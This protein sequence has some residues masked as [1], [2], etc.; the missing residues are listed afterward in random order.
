MAGLL[1][2][3]SSTYY[4]RRQHTPDKQEMAGNPVRMRA[5][6]TQTVTVL[7]VINDLGIGGAQRIVAELAKRIDHARFRPIVLNLG[8]SSGDEIEKEL[9]KAGVVVVR[10][11]NILIFDITNIY[12]I[13]STIRNFNVSIVHSHLFRANLIS[14]LA[15]RVA[16]IKRVVSTE[17][18]TTTFTTR[19]WWYKQASRVYLHRN[20]F[21]LAVSRAVAAAIASL[22]QDV[23]H[24]TR[25]IYNGID[26]TTFAPERYTHSDVK[27]SRPDRFTVGALLRPD[28]RKGFA[29]LQ[30][31]SQEMQQSDPGI[32]FVMGY[33]EKRLFG[34]KADSFTWI[35]MQA[36]AEGTAR[37]LLQLDL[38]VLPS[39]EEGLGI[40]ALEAM[41][42]GIAVIASDV[43]GLAEVITH[44]ENGLLVQAGDV[45]ALKQAIRRLQAD[46]ALRHRLADAGQKRVRE[47]FGVD[48][49]IR[50]Y[51]KVY[52]ELL[53]A[54]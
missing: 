19:P 25:V 7:Y 6:A 9:K 38:F 34:K 48:E 52:E 21:H 18:N 44:E 37:Y 17:H 14:S 53:W 35:A 29:V 24:K 43:G 28:P 20:R 8:F 3:F 16:G 42:M 27:H 47:K 50:A 45:Q 30:A 22:D 54:S 10:A 5:D 11:S 39:L 1:Q 51:E 46:E 31:C 12:T 23:A 26:L 15:A 4:S 41:A 33:R 2:Y 40:A 13:F 32:D 49:M 36:G